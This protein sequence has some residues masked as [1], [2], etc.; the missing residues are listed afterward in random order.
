MRT[1]KK[2]YWIGF[3]VLEVSYWSFHASFIGFLMSY[4]LTK[5]ITNTLVSIFLASFLLAAFI[6]SFIWGM[7]CDR[8]HTN[9]KVSIVCFL[10][11]GVLMYLIYFSYDSI[12][13]LAILYPLLGFVSLPHATNIDSWLL[14]ACENNLSIYGKIRCLPSL[15]FAV[16][17]VILG[18]LVSAFGYHFMLIFGTFFLLTGIAAAVMLPDSKDAAQDKPAGGF[19]LHSLKQIFSTSSNTASGYSYLIIILL[20]VGLAVSPMNNLKTAVLQSVG[21]TVSDIGIDAFICAITQVPF[22]ALADKMEKYSLRLRYILIALLPFL[23]MAL[24]FCAVSPVMIFAGSCLLNMGVGILLP[25]MRSVT[26]RNVAPAY[27][28]LGHNI[29]DAVYNSVAGIASLLYSGFVIDRF[30]VKSMLFLCIL[31]VSI[32]VII[33]LHDAVRHWAAALRMRGNIL[34]KES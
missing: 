25:T 22:I 10:T 30:G 33:T 24:A 13:V 27:R 11:A 7:V 18:Q 29:A 12:L 3:S 9:R 4:L 19:S 32:P 31:I 17:S 26:E 28:N 34:R 1:M 15:M 2:S 23:T 21:G 14:L 5:G 20:L 16:T 8:F 6:G